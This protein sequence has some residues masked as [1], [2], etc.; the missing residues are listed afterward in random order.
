MTCG[1]GNWVYICTKVITVK[2]TSHH[3]I[4]YTIHSAME[5]NIKSLQKSATRRYSEYG[6]VCV[7]SA[8]MD[9]LY[10]KI[11][12]IRTAY[13]PTKQ[14]P[15]LVIFVRNILQS[16]EPVYKQIVEWGS[17]H[18]RECNALVIIYVTGLVLKMYSYSY[19]LVNNV[20]IQSTKFHGVWKMITNHKVTTLDIGFYYN[21]KFQFLF[22]QIFNLLLGKSPKNA[23]LS[24]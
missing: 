9:V 1:W 11:K 6:K 21:S 5:E 12:F 8:H 2:C 17:Y 13:P 3:W 7:W 19:D 20:T 16:G 18:F 4:M 10:P 22:T 23:A 14:F 24:L 15:N